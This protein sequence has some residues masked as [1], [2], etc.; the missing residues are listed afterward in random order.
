MLKI[1]SDPFHECSPHIVEQHLSQRAVT[2]LVMILIGA[3]MTGCSSEVDESLVDR[4]FVTQQ[5]CPP[6]CWYGL[7]I[8]KSTE[9]ELLSTLK[10]LPFID[11]ASIVKYNTVWQN[12]ENA[13]GISYGCLSVREDDWKTRCGG[14]DFSG[15]KLKSLWMAVNYELTFG[16]AVDLLN[17]PSHIDY[18]PYHAEV[19]GGGCI[20]D[21]IWPDK[22]IVIRA[23]Q[24]TGNSICQSLR[25]GNGIDSNTEVQSIYYI[26]EEAFGPEPRACCTRISWPGFTKP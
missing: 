16:T 7:Q 22:G 21:L 2:W 10:T 4:S 3:V 17:Q 14:A 13:L 9:G 6:P 12:D 18:G 20:V 11:Q 26:A 24:T 25:D 8:D 1:R 5:P 19:S 23:V 15:G